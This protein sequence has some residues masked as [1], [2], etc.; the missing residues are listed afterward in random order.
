MTG[1][2]P[3]VYRNPVLKLRDGVLHFKFEAILVFRP[4]MTKVRPKI[5][6]IERESCPRVGA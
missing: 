6:F 5:A 2:S 1:T 4:E 3:V